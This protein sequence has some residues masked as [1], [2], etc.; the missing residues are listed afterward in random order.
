MNNSLDGLL[1]LPHIRVENANA[2]SGP[3]TWGFPAPTAFTGFVHA[4]Q[5]KLQDENSSL[6]GVGIICHHFAPQV[7]QPVGQRYHCF[8]LARHPL[9]KEAKPAS[10]VEEGRAHLEI[11]LLIGI[12][13]DLDKDEGRRFAERVQQMALEMRLAG[14]SILPMLSGLRYVAQYFELSGTQEGNQAVFRQLRRHLLPGFVLVSRQELLQNYLSE[15]HQQNPEITALDALLELVAL[16]IQ[17]MA[18]TGEKTSWQSF[19]KLR[20]WLVPLSIGYGA[21]SPLHEAGSVRN[22]RDVTTP[23]RFVETLTSLG[24]WLSPHRLNQP[25]ELL[26][27]YR[28]DAESGL[29]LCQHLQH[30]L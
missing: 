28:A 18:Q 9:G 23:F 27:F 8:C 26:W 5:R 17:P 2:I 13:G 1:L 6:D 7:Y 20:G 4:L 29:Y 12:R 16:H 21:I 25:E 24:E 14:G 15:R 19:R 10:T 11:S 30:H 22:T 3:M